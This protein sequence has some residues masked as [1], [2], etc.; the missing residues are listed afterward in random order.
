MNVEY[1]MG[2]SITHT[3]SK[4]IP[5]PKVKTERAFFFA[6]SDYGHQMSNPLPISF[7]NKKKLINNLTRLFNIIKNLY[8][9]KYFPH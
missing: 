3:Y 7:K 5:K 1:N 6:N 8:T 2:A 4:K 9:W